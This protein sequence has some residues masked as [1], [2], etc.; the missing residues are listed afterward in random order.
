MRKGL[1]GARWWR[2]EGE[3]RGARREGF[4][5]RRKNLA[6]QRAATPLR[7]VAQR[8]ELS[9]PHF[10]P[11]FKAREV[12]ALARQGIMQALC[13]T[14]RLLINYVRGHNEWGVSA[15]RADPSDRCLCGIFLSKPYS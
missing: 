3:W 9:V 7:G 10:F 11:A 13:T 5:A 6:A 15:E 12:A 8:A 1:A 2:C 4:V 14:N